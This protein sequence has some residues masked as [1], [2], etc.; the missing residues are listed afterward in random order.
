MGKLNSSLDFTY[1]NDADAAVAFAG[2]G[3]DFQEL[4]GN[5]LENAAKFAITRV[6]T[7]LTYNSNENVF[8]V[9]IDDD[10]PGIPEEEFATVLERGARLDEA[11]PGTGLGLSI[12]SDILKTYSGEVEFSKS[13]LG[14]LRVSVVL[15]AGSE[16]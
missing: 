16:V 8:T 12:V 3:A 14:G 1:N 6:N 4:F 13:P 15:S 10:G 5:L 11:V 7:L 2:E 9:V